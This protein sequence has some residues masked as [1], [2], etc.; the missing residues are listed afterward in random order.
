MNDAFH[1]SY[2]H[3]SLKILMVNDDDAKDVVVV[4][5]GLVVGGNEAV[6]LMKLR[7]P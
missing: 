3:W 1:I 5:R 2:K 4:E 6:V 7:W